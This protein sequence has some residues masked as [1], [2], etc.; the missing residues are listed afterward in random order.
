MFIV[1]SE[2]GYLVEHGESEQDDT[3]ALVFSDNA[4][5][6]LVIES[7]SITLIAA[8]FVGGDAVELCEA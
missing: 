7:E 1:R 4:A 5:D 2:H 8:A 6:A 3:L